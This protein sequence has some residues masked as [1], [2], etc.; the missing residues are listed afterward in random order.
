MLTL[1]LTNRLFMLPAKKLSLLLFI[2]IFLSAC[3]K[4][5]FISNTDTKDVPVTLTYW[6][7]WEDQ[8][9]IQPLIDE[10][11][12]INP[13]ITVN[14]ARQNI[15]NY[16]ERL[17]S[18]LGT[19]SGPDLFRFHNTWVPMFNQKL[20]SVPET[21]YTPKEFQQTFYPI[22]SKDLTVGNRIVGVPLEVDGLTL[23]YNEDLLK[24]AGFSAPPQTWEELRTM[25]S[26]ITVI[27][28]Q[29]RIKTSGVALGT[30]GN[31]DHFS[32]ILGLLMAQNQ[33]KFNDLEKSISTDG[34]NLATDA[35]IFYSS[36]RQSKI[37]DET[38]PKSTV[39]FSQGSL[40]FYFA[41]SW[42][43]FEI[44]AANPNLNFRA[45]TVPQLT[46]DSKRKVAWAS[47]WSE[48]VSSTISEEK[49][50]AAW[51]FLKFIS[52]A[53]SQ[54]KIYSYQA[55]TRDF[56]EPYSRVDLAQSVISNPVVGA[57]LQD[58]VKATSYPIA[59]NTF[60]NGI[61]DLNINYLAQV[62]DEANTT[63]LSRSAIDKAIITL[64]K[65]W[66]QVSDQFDG[67]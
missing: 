13:N 59:S 16:R 1:K 55:E 4:L 67:N 56:G 5:P 46:T 12:A 45:T 50:A 34:K 24:A 22:T 17:S 3:S 11:T 29:A 15:T 20:A 63:N 53:E 48:G 52:S 35:V 54:Q 7:L 47:Y 42:K 9:V 41:P 19:E 28:E 18:A 49:Q 66:K 39:M 25:A 27:D 64:A 26:Q 43:Y 6:G 44:K 57:V 8:Q 40:A 10:F 2:S 62:V 36:F 37:W 58:M 33:V 60:D 14:Y 65:G 21:I 23:F 32:D 61:N 30:S 31:V 51:K 38:L